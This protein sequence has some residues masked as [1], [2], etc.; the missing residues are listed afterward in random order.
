[1]NN[2]TAGSCVNI[3]S[4]T[5]FPRHVY[6]TPV[7]VVIIALLTCI[8]VLA[9]AGNSLVIIAVRTY[10]RLQTLTNA[11][12]VSLAIA[13]I[14]VGIL[15]MPLEI[16]KHAST[17]EW[18]LGHLS[19]LYLYS[20]TIMMCTASIYNIVCL[21]IDRY[22]AT[23]RPFAHSQTSQHSVIMLILGS[24]LSPIFL[25]FVP[26]MTEWH[27]IGIEDKVN[28][29]QF[30]GNNRVCFVIIN[31]QFA[32]I[33][34]VLA[35]YLPAFVLMFLHWRMYLSAKEAIKKIQP[36]HDKTRQLINLREKK[37][38][39]TVLAIMGCFTT[40]WLPFYII[41]VADPFLNHT[42]HDNIWNGMLWLGYMHS[43]MNPFL[44]YAFNR[45]FRHAFRRL[46][47]KYRIWKGPSHPG[48]HWMITT[49]TT[50]RMVIVS[51]MPVSNIYSSLSTC[52]C[53]PNTV[54]QKKEA[55]NVSVPAPVCRAPVKKGFK[56]RVQRLSYQRGTFQSN[57]RRNSKINRRLN[58]QRRNVQV[59][60]GMAKRIVT[61]QKQDP[62]GKRR[63]SG[64][65][66]AKVPKEAS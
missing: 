58:S 66:P 60:R 7:V 2:S 31:R 40:C 38:A 61:Q 8:T 46:F 65:S 55:E 33:L 37:P 30:L 28:C 3:M 36:S 35:F 42:I 57:Q 53:G 41:N 1:M 63:G 4:G 21:T 56:A 50:S 19:C 10:T 29:I 44:L 20:I 64:G 26:V 9:I 13:D 32:V 15:V 25:S 47:V 5:A 48:V 24:W 23:C 12:V 45:S 54:I 51:E 59:L 39:K 62:K 18:N 43:V 16:Y 17:K 6:G 49:K 27:T 22:T 34:S 14:S 52:D 11:Y